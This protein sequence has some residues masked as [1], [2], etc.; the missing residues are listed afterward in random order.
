MAWPDIVVLLLLLFGA[1][2]G[3]RVGL[4]GELTGMVALATAVTA[5]FA[6]PGMWDGFAQQRTGLGPGSAHVV[7]MLAFAAAV[8]GIVFMVGFAFGRIAKLPIIGTVNAGLGAAVG[9]VKTTIIVWAIL[10]VALFFPLSRDLRNDLRR[11]RFVVVLETPND[12][13]DE[14]LRSSLPWFVRP[15]SADL[16]ARHRV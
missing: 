10:Y 16:F 15:Y 9:V 4:I 11:S 6:Y 12:R 3:W 7:A 2:R 1:L 8:Y 5:A 14:T 13:F